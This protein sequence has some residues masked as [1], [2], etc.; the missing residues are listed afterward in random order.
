MNTVMIPTE[1][2]ILEVLIAARQPTDKNLSDTMR[3]FFVN[4]TEPAFAA[5]SGKSVTVSPQ[6]QA[7]IK[8]GKHRYELIGEQ[9]TASSAIDVLIDIL[10]TLQELDSSFLEKLAPKIRGTSVNHLAR[11][12]GQVCPNRL[13]Q[14]RRVKSVSP[15]WYI[16]TIISNNQKINFLKIACNITGLKFGVDL[17]VDFLDVVLPD[18]KRP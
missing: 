10:A 8:T 15:G 14:E 3:R 18:L 12:I 2:D 4:R 7:V 5:K 13:D 9:R 6:K 11:S 16:G 17:I 1:I